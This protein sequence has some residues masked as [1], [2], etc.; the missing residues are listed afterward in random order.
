MNSVATSNLGWAVDKTSGA[1]NMM[2]DTS[3]KVSG[4]STQWWVPLETLLTLWTQ[5]SSR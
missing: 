3:G 1:V 4:S 2:G 5:Y